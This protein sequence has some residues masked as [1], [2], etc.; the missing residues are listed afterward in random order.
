MWLRMSGCLRR[1]RP[2]YE[3]LYRRWRVQGDCVLGDSPLSSGER[4]G[5]LAT[6]RLEHDYELFGELSRKIPA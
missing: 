3:A 2:Q 5:D 4:S 1:Q 6:Y